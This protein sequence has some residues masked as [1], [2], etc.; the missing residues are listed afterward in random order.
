MTKSDRTALRTL[1]LCQGVLVAGLALSFPFMTLYLHQRRGLPM[2]MTGLA[3][4]LSVV[5]TAVGQGLGGELSDLWGCKRVMSA[6]LAGRVVLMILMALAI[7]L[8]WPVFVIVTL[9]VCA[10]FFGSFYDPAVRAWIAGEHPAAGR[11][12]AYGQLRVATNAAW[13]VGPAVGGLMAGVSYALMFGVT[14]ALCLVC[15]GLLVWVVPDAPV[16]RTGEGFAWGSVASVS[17][18]RRFLEFCGLSVLAATVMSHL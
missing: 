12:R 9:L 10:G 15:L 18:D 11:V 14:S 5:A 17:K 3:V 13:A 6:S 7:A 16:S 2:G 8:A 4:S 1:L